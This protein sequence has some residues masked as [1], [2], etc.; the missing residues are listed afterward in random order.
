MIGTL[1]PTLSYTKLYAVVQELKKK[2][3]RRH[4]FHHYSTIWTCQWQLRTNANM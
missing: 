4:Q 1:L 2:T 3:R